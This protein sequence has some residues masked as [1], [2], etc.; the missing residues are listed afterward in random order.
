MESLKA[1]PRSET[2]L[3]EGF[4]KRVVKLEVVPSLPKESYNSLVLSFKQLKKYK[5]LS[6]NDEVH[7]LKLAQVGDLKARDII[8]CGN[9][10]LIIKIAKRYGGCGL[11]LSELLAVG[12]EIVSYD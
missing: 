12:Q 7:Y 8:I 6:S 2:S 1:I 5:L 4:K 3:R 11:E 10:R 9:L